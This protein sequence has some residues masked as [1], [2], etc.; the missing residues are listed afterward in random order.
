MDM[1]RTDKYIALDQ[2]MPDTFTGVT[3]FLH[4]QDTLQKTFPGFR[5]KNCANGGH[6]KGLSI[7]RR[8]TFVTTNDNGGLSHRQTHWVNSHAM[9]PLQL[10]ADTGP[11]GGG[12]ATFML[13]GVMMGGM[14]D[15]HRFG[16]DRP[17]PVRPDRRETMRPS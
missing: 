14:D 7:Q 6:Y 4:I 12:N 11:T 5:Y 2:P 8:M 15:E 10:K 9:S 17:Q 13:R 3:N 16:R 1:W